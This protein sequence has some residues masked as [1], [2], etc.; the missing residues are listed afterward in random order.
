L[1][2]FQKSVGENS[3][4]IKNQTRIKGTL[5]EDQFTFLIMSRLTLLRMKIVSDKSCTEI[6]NTHFMFNNFFLKVMPFIR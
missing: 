2:V 1:R 3:S 5:H 6:W 4:F